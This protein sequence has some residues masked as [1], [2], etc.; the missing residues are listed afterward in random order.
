[1]RFCNQCSR[2]SPG[3]PPYC[4]HCGRSYNVRLCPR[5]HANSRRVTFCSECGSDVL[6]TP[7]PPEDWGVKLSRWLLLGIVVVAI[8]AVSVSV[9][10]AIGTRIPWAGLACAV[11]EVLIVYWLLQW[12]VPSPVKRAA[13]A[14][15]RPAGK[16]LKMAGKAISRRSAG[17]RNRRVS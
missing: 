14:V 8:S 6:S 2:Y 1:M 5:G 9:L 10:L 3:R 15:G 16:A 11:L 7:A 13:G 17:R 12:L 4:P